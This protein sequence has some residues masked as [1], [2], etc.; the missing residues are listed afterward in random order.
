MKETDHIR[1]DKKVLQSSVYPISRVFLEKYLP[2]NSIYLGYQEDSE[3]QEIIIYYDQ[4]AID[5]RQ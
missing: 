4:E 2:R 3:T 1:I 5:G